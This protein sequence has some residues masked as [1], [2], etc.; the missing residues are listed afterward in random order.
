MIKHFGYRMITTAPCLLSAAFE[1]EYSVG[2]ILEDSV[3]R[4]SRRTPTPLSLPTGNGQ[5]FHPNL[6]LFCILSAS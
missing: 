3:N 2:S 5:I 1:S 4:I 6:L